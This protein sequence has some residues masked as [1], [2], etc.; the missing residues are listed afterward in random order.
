MTVEMESFLHDVGFV[1]GYF[2]GC[3]LMLALLVFV[4]VKWLL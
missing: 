2:V 3:R 1:M 4:I